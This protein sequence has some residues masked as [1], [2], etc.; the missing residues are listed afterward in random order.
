MSN[1][2][3]KLVSWLFQTGALRVCPQDKP[4]WYTSGAIGPYYINT[5]FLY[6]SEDKANNLLKIIDSEKADKIK[7]PVKLLEEVLSNYSKDAIFKELIDEMTKFVQESPEMKNF[8]YISGGER[9]DWFF[10][11]IIAH[12]LKKPHITIYKD[13]TVAVLDDG[14]VNDGID[15]NGKKVL[16]IADLINEASS[17]ERAWIPA[18]KNLG[19]EIKWSMAV[20]DRMQG[21]AEYLNSRNIIPF[22]MINIDKELFERALDCGYINNSQFEM[23]DEYINNPKEAMKNFLKNNPEFMKNALVSDEKTKERA[24]LCIE[25]KIYE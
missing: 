10:S 25:K 15:I 19:G 2:K 24:K 21:G 4:F 1:L 8:D 7:C 14:K 6:G 9:R 11:I 23:I 3:E 16:H 13:L 12:F 5:H 22:S 18:I 17:Y 20:V